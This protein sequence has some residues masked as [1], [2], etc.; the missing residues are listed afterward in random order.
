MPDHRHDDYE[1]NGVNGLCVPNEREAI[2]LREA[3]M[4]AL[5]AEFLKMAFM[6]T[7]HIMQ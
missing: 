7:E 6:C 4:E 5:N 3:F 2:I 1:R